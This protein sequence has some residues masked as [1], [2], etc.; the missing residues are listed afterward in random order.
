MAW[1]YDTK[2][3]EF[4][5]Y[6]Y[7]GITTWGKILNICIPLENCLHNSSYLPLAIFLI[8]ISVITFA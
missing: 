5:N 8:S 4:D 6:I 2:S 1:H 7:L 3:N